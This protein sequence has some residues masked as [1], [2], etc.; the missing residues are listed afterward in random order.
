MYI[1][2]R[3]GRKIPVGKEMHIVDD[4]DCVTSESLTELAKNEEVVCECCFWGGDDDDESVMP[5]RAACSC[6]GQSPS[7]YEVTLDKN[8]TK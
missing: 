6:Q 7:G 1:C 2:N 3:C 4:V 5:E 8:R